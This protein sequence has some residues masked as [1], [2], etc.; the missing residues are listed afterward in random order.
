MGLQGRE[1]VFKILRKRKFLENLKS[2][3]KI[4]HDNIDIENPIIVYLIK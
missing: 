2:E 3:M 4:S 1:I